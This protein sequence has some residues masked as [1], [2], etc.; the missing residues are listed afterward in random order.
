M[1]VN[2]DNEYLVGLVRELCKLP[3]EAEWV[4]FKVNNNEPEAIGEYIS[5]L[6]NAAA[7]HGKTRAYMLWGCGGPDPSDH[8]Y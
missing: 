4:E 8:R 3:Q 6:S 2:R 1:N 7:L 5:G